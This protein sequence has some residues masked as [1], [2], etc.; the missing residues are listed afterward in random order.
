[1]NRGQVIDMLPNR[2]NV[3]SS[4]LLGTTTSHAFFDHPFGIAF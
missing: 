4:L 2:Q 1:M 3:V